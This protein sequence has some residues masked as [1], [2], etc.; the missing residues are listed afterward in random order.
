LGRG[1]QQVYGRGVYG[2]RPPLKVDEDDTWGTTAFYNL[3]RFGTYLDADK[4][5]KKGANGHQGDS[6]KLITPLTYW[7]LDD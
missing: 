2:E 5:G 1:Q 7:S 6:F 3:P 4:G